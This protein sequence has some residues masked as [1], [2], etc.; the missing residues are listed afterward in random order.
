MQEKHTPQPEQRQEI[1]P[2]DSCDLADIHDS[3][4]DENAATRRASAGEHEATIKRLDAIAHVLLDAIGMLRN[5]V[6]NHVVP[7]LDYYV[8]K[9]DAI[10]RATKPTNNPKTR[11]KRPG[12]IAGIRLPEAGQ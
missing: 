10:E 3:I 11:K 5:R 4:V 2:I 1:P 12:T 8:D 9:L 7:T 6:E